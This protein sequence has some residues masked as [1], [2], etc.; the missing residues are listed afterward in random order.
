MALDTYAN[1]L[2]ALADEVERSDVAA[3]AA[4]AVAMAEALMN[5]RLRVNRMVTRAQATVTD[6]FSDVPA[7]FLQPITMRAVSSPY[8]PLRFLT[9]NQMGDFKNALPSG[10]LAYYGLVGT[11]FEYGPT[12]VETQDVELTYY[13]QIPALVSNSTNWLLVLH[14][15]AYFHGAMLHLANWEEDQERA[16]NHASLFGAA[17]EGIEDDDRRSSYAA[18]LT[19]T[20]SAYVV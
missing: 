6:G 17:L 12:P 13:A 14:P 19:P 5:R 10:N 7:D 1:L 9:G 3:K 20:A 18:N 2:L 15:D 16:T 4:D 11:E 8:P